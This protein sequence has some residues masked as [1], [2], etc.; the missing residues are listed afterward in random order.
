MNNLPLEIILDICK[1]LTPGH[2]YNLCI[3]NKNMY[4]GLYS[5]FLLRNHKES[6]VVYNFI[7][8]TVNRLYDNRYIS[9][10]THPFISNTRIE[11]NYKILTLHD[12][13]LINL[14]NKSDISKIDNTLF[15]NG[16]ISQLKIITAPSIL[17]KTL[18][19]KLR[20]IYKVNSSTKGLLYLSVKK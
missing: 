7:K 11:C 14:I 19:D 2:I 4:Y 15:I 1:Y 13:N 8:D 16:K 6:N 3:V 12:I 5:Y 20:I 17:H 10:I 9:I 18:F